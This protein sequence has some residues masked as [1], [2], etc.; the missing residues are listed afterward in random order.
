MKI[1]Y[2]SEKVNVEIIDGPIGIFASGGTDSSLLL[3][4]VMKY[5][6]YPL[7]IFTC[8]STLKGRTNSTIISKVIEKCIQ[9][10][11][12]MNIFQHNYYVDEQTKDNIW[13]YPYS[14][15]N[16]NKISAIYSG[17]TANPPD[18]IAYSFFEPNTENGER[19]PKVERPYWR[20]NNTLYSPFTNI[21]KKNI[22]NIYKQY[23]LIDTLFAYTRSCEKICE[24]ADDLEYYDH[25]G[26]CWWC[27][28]RQWGFGKL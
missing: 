17:S 16:E 26:K 21:D 18:E 11:G 22:A 6:N 3:Y 25:C 2:L 9:L 20:Y 4:F 7:H 8:S 5:T 23:N 24:S 28:E 1:I 19:D 15:L 13:E 27:E 12:N 14:F 10:T